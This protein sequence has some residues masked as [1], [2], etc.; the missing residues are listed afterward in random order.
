MHW[1]FISVPPLLIFTHELISSLPLYMPLQLFQVICRHLLLVEQLTSVSGRHIS[2]SVTCPVL[3]L[4]ICS[5]SVKSVTFPRCY[6]YYIQLVLLLTIHSCLLGK[7]C[8]AAVL[9]NG[10]LTT[11]NPID[12]PSSKIPGW[13]IC[14]PLY[15]SY[16]IYLPLV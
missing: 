16:M 13:L 2:S 1:F 12:A 8:L 14:A 15:Q 7:A 5:S 11:C 9:S 4:D 3:S 6:C 10:S